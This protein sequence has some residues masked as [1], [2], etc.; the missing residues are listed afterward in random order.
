GI[1]DAAVINTRLLDVAAHTTDWLLTLSPTSGDGEGVAANGMVSYNKLHDTTL[2]SISREA[3]VD[4]QFVRVNAERSLGVLAVTGAV[5]KSENSGVGIGVAMNEVT[6]ITRASIGDNDTDGGGVDTAE[7]TAGSI[8]T[9]QLDVGARS[10][11]LIVAVGVAG[12]MAGSEES[13]GAGG[14]GSASGMGDKA[15]GGAGGAQSSLDGAGT[16]ALSGVGDSLTAEGAAGGG[17]G[18]GEEGGEGEGESK[19]PAFSIAGAGAIVT[20]FSD[21]DTTA[22]IDRAVVLGQ[23]SGS[24]GVG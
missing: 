9:G 19:P 12:A 21:V 15:G 6:G 23:G 13:P 11:G 14:G 5:T 8:R 4:A 20:N 10:D 16:A 3:P 7:G 17:E 24:T 18:G 1:A 2:A 22:L